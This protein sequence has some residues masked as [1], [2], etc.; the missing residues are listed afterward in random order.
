MADTNFMNI[1]DGNTKIKK[2]RDLTVE[3]ST[4]DCYSIAMENETQRV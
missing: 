4:S 1:F 3:F 2:C